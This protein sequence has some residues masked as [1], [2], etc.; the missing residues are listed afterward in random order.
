MEEETRKRGK[1]RRG[2]DKGR[3]ERR[4]ERWDGNGD[5]TGETREKGKGRYREG[6]E[7]KRRENEYG[8]KGICLN[9]IYRR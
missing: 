3:D 5:E 8:E 6:G 7:W 9:H 2:G 4:G 1:G